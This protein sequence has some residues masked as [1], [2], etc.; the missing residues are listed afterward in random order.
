MKCTVSKEWKH[1]AHWNLQFLHLHIYITCA[2]LDPTYSFIFHVG[3]VA[4]LKESV[5]RILQ[6]TESSV[7]EKVD[8]PRSLSSDYG[9]PDKQAVVN[10]L[11]SRFRKWL[12]SHGFP[13][14]LKTIL[15]YIDKWIKMV[16]FK[17]GFEMWKVNW[18]KRYEQR[19]KKKFGVPDRNQAHDLST[20]M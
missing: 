17:L 9:R 19:T 7:L 16:N 10:A 6:G 18:S 4:N 3:Y 11:K 14:S 15:Q 12:S 1:L 5:V 8:G 2:W 20:T 13:S